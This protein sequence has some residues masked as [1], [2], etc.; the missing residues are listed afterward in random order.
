MES[1]LWPLLQGWETILGD[2]AWPISSGKELA[3]RL[4]RALKKTPKPSDFS[5]EA[6]GSP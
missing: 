1:L 5:V 4:W 3:L 6:L 2:Q